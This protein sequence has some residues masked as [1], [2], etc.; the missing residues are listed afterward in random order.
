MQKSGQFLE[1]KRT[2]EQENLCHFPAMQYS[3]PYSAKF[4][5]GMLFTEGLLGVTKRPHDV[6]NDIKTA[7]QTGVT[8]QQT[9]EPLERVKSPTPEA[10]PS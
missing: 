7:E 5:Q 9:P 10:G 6:I 1:Q 3:L 8:A 2:G 4:K